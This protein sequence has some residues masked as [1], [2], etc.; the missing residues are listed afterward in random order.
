MERAVD[1]KKD[2]LVAKR[3]MEGAFRS[4]MGE[5]LRVKRGVLI[6]PA[7]AAC[8]VIQQRVL[9]RFRAVNEQIER[10]LGAHDART[11]EEVKY[12]MIAAADEVF[13]QFEWAGRSAWASRPLEAQEHRT[14]DAGERVFFTLDEILERRA[15]RPTE[16]LLVYLHVLAIGFRG[17][18]A[19]IDVGRQEEYRRRLV[20]HLH[21]LGEPLTRPDDTLCPDALSHTIKQHSR[22]KLESLGRGAIP[23]IIAVVAWLVL[24][25]VL[26]QVRTSALGEILDRIEAV[27]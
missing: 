21:R 9:D 18:Y 7:A 14:H 24:G 27:R 4:F 12:L 20:E 23:L 10:R 2:S 13:L 8:D 6:A 5:V 17:R 11:Y 3:P 15:T 1:H 25:A 16:I 22:L 26:F 19:S